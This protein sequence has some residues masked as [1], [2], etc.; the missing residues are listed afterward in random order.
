MEEHLSFSYCMDIHRAYIYLD[1]GTAGVL[2]MR[3]VQRR[4]S[5]CF[6]NLVRA[7]KAYPTL[8]KSQG[9]FFPYSPERRGREGEDN[10]L[11]VE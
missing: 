10:T 6:L 1:L 4:E 9:L 8:R 11:S 7:N 5:A 3:T 2:F